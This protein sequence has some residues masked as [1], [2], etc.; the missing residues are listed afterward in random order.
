MTLGVNH[1]F[2]FRLFF[3]TKVKIAKGLKPSSVENFMIMRRTTDRCTSC[4][5][6]LRVGESRN[7]LSRLLKKGNEGRNLLI[8]L[9]WFG[10]EHKVILTYDR[11][12][13]TLHFYIRKGKK[14]AEAH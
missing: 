3:F 13:Y 11:F 2:R 6:F 7:A 8:F 5:T 12:Q 10:R 9:F 1:D 14:T 4:S